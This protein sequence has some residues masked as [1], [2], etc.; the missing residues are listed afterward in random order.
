MRALPYYL[1]NDQ[2]FYVRRDALI[3][4]KDKHPFVSI[5]AHSGFSIE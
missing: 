3:A 1:L 4:K 2:V 5:A